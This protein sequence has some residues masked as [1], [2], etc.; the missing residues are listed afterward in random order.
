M[1]IFKVNRNIFDRMKVEAGAQYDIMM[2]AFKEAKEK[3]KE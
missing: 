1:E 3:F 2:A